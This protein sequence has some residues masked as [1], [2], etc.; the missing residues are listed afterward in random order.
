MKKGRRL[1]TI[2]E[3]HLKDHLPGMIMIGVDHLLVMTMIEEGHHKDMITIGGDRRLDMTTIEEVLH[4][5][6]T[7]IGVVLPHHTIEMIL[8]TETHITRTIITYQPL[9]K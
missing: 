2:I 6:T 5:P 4:L 1:I 9:Q 8:I 3:D 7:T